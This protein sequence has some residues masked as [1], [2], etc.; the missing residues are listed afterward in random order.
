MANT[1]K[2]GWIICI[3]SMLSLFFS[4]CANYQSGVTF[5]KDGS[6]YIEQKFS[7]SETFKN[8]IP[9]AQNEIKDLANKARKDGFD[10]KESSDGYIGTQTYKSVNDLVKSGGEIWN[11]TENYNG[12]QVRKGFLYDYYYLDLFLK[13]G[14]KID[15]DFNYQPNIPGYFSPNNHLN[16]GLKYY[17]QRQKAEQEAAEINRAANQTMK[18]SI[19]SAKVDFT[20]NLPYEADSSNAD[21]KENGNK[22]LTWNLK[23][24]ALGEQDFHAQLKFKIYHENNIII[25]AVCGGLMLIIAI[26]LIIIG[27]IKRDNPKYR[28]TLFGIAILIFI[29]GICSAAYVKYALDNPPVLTGPDR[30]FA[31][32]AKDSEGN[33]LSDSLKKQEKTQLNQLDTVGGVL[34]SKGIEGNILATSEKDENGF[35]SLMEING[36]YYF[37]VYD[38]KDDFAAVVQYHSQKD[39]ENSYRKLLEFR[40]NPT[41]LKNG[42]KSYHP[43]IFNVEINDDDKNGKD[44]GLGVWQGTK[45]IFPIYAVFKVDENDKVI[46][47]MLSSGKGLYPSHYQAYL[48]ET[49]NVNIGNAVLTHIDSLKLDIRKRQIN[50]PENG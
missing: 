37:A 44:Q 42:T 43:V 21:V 48:N 50:L 8:V 1:I 9:N 41:V 17:E 4:G 46:P 24:A 16:S 11:P 13:K 5:N 47:G 2:N 19:D 32:Q 36:K 25:L 15:L 3:V 40:T 28:N 18:A 33:L 34:K 20:I 39:A 31:E 30:I 23:S 38:A 10:V 22:S 27:I 35:L 45:H 26:I 12:V 49:R 7:A 6:I 29:G 14:K